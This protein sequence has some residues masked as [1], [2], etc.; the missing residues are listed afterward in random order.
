MHCVYLIENSL[1]CLSG[2][3]G[4]RPIMGFIPWCWLKSAKENV[5]RFQCG[6]V[7]IHVFTFSSGCCSFTAMFVR[8]TYFVK[9]AILG[10]YRL[11]FLS[12]LICN[13]ELRPPIANV[14]LLM[15]SHW[16]LH[17]KICNKKL[18]A[19]FSTA[20]SCWQQMNRW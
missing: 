9:E 15:I 13:C 6:V 14:D 19:N 11:W 1:Q 17:T 8:Y 2:W 12:E 10:F 4:V 5:V 20:K 16:Q 3:K 7:C 18:F